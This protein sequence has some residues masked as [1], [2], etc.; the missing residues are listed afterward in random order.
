M[1]PYTAWMDGDLKAYLWRCCTS[2]WN[3][4][5]A[6]MYSWIFSTWA[7][8]PAIKEV[9]VSAMAWQPSEHASFPLAP[10]TLSIWEKFWTL[11]Y[12]DH[13]EL[14]IC[15]TGDRRVSDRPSIATLID[16][17]NGD[18]ASEVS[19]WITFFIRNNLKPK[20]RITGSARTRKRAAALFA[21][22]SFVGRPVGQ[23]ARQSPGMPCQECH[24]IWRQRRLDRAR[25]KS[26]SV[27]IYLGLLCI[28][29]R[30]QQIPG[31]GHKCQPRKQCP[32][33]LETFNWQTIRALEM[34]P[35]M[36]PVPY[37]ICILRPSSL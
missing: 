21:A 3:N 33:N 22:Q 34:N 6:P 16:A 36:E 18:F 4:G 2:P 10:L 13:L 8:G 17:A 15:F 28:T 29:S 32:K 12:S 24:Q 30:P 27:W 23:Q 20:E 26:V 37:W 5:M 11:F 19:V 7:L 1:I 25:F 31:P 9:P 14:P 35:F